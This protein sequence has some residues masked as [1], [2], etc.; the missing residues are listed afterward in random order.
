MYI[1]HFE[2]SATV[3]KLSSSSPA[4][5]LTFSTAV[6]TSDNLPTPDGSIIITS[7]EYSA[8]T[9]LSASPKS[10][11]REQQMHPEFISLICTPASLRKPPSIP[12]SP[13]SFSIRTTFCPLYISSSNFLIKVVFPA[14]KK[15][16]IIVTLLIIMPLYYIIVVP[17]LPA[18]ASFAFSRLAITAFL[19]LPASTNPTAAST[20]GNVVIAPRLSLLIYCLRS[21]AE[22]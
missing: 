8:D 2:E 17:V 11:T 20:L 13:N 3:M 22:T 14:P 4:S 19:S 5:S 21:S 10:P 18:R 7:G 16:E 6:I 9:F 1:L 12:I 15:P